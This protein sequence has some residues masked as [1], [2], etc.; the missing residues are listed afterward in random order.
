MALQL[1][2]LMSQYTWTHLIAKNSITNN[3]VFCYVSD[4]KMIIYNNRLEND[5][6]NNNNRLENDNRQQQQQIGK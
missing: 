3:V 5:N 2:Y 1:N 4:G 6:N